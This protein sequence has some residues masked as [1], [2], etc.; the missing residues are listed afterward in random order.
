MN[1][2]FILI[3]GNLGN[4]FKNLHTAKKLIQQHCGNIVAASSIYQT[5]A[6]GMQQQPDF[7]NQ[8]LKIE[9]A[10][11]PHQLL[12]KLLEIENIIGR[13]REEKYGP[14][15]IDLDILLFNDETVDDEN[16]KIPHPH[17][18]QR[19]FALVPLNEVAADYFH[20]VEKKTIHQLLLKCADIL[21]VKKITATHS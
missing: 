19:K 5:A 11:Q 9:T 3:G 20:P 12:K 13:I 7:Y 6:W 15:I 8:A 2:A 17:L 21:N 10:F 14:R 18:P 4:R 1:T 16:L